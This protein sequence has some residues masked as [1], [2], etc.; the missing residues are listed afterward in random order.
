MPSF[1]MNNN[2]K[3]V[4]FAN[5]CWK[6]L[7]D[8]FLFVNYFCFPFFCFIA[9]IWPN[10]VWFSVSDSGCLRAKQSYAWQRV[11][12]QQQTKRNLKLVAFF[13]P[14]KP[15]FL[16]S[17]ILWIQSRKECNCHIWSGSYPHRFNM[18]N[19]RLWFCHSIETG[20][21]K[22]IWITMRFDLIDSAEF[23]AIILISF[24]PKLWLLLYGSV[25]FFLSSLWRAFQ[26]QF[27]KCSIILW[28]TV[29][30]LCSSNSDRQVY[31]VLCC[32]SI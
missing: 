3:T 18:I 8:F 27:T 11:W 25:L 5:F 19:S 20:N 4:H 26:T 31:N 9:C 13:L 28:K 15:Y 1:L 12:C 10:I 2:K 24:T 6:K 21:N 7:G 16:R 22:T 17:K 30:L 29:S 23:C 14:Q 32:Y